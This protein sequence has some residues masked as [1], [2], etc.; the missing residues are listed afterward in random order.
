MISRK[1][2]RK[3]QI[4]KTTSTPDNFG[5]NDVS[6]VLI[7]SFWSEVKQLASNKD[8][9]IGNVL[10]KTT[11]SFKIRANTQTINTSLIQNDLS[12]VY[13]GNNYNVNEITYNDELFRE[14]NLIANG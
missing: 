10:T 2:N 11:Y 9:S 8:N 6:L 1:Y 7:G 13:R 4:F 3:I 12:I 14:V 5:G